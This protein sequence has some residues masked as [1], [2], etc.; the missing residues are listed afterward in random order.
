M[1]KKYFW[2]F[3]KFFF[4]NFW[5]FFFIFMMLIFKIRAQFIEVQKWPKKI[6]FGKNIKMMSMVPI[7]PE[8][9]CI[10]LP[11]VQMELPPK[12][13]RR[14]TTFIET[15]LRLNNIYGSPFLRN[16]KSQI[17]WRPADIA[18]SHVGMRTP[19]KSS[20]L[21]NN[22]LKVRPFLWNQLKINFRLIFSLI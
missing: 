19:T 5:N 6:F 3:W 8:E 16:W 22:I 9:G 10:S 7:T 20:I 2:N 11:S 1:K 14:Q 13:L 12:D 15:I 4:E 17:V 18:P 21:Y